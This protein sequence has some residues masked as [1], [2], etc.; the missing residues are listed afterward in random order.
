MKLLL[1]ALFSL[2]AAVA[3]AHDSLVPH[4]HP[5]G[6][7]ML[8]GFDTVAVALLALAAALVAYWKFGRT[9]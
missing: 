8:P 3:H 6:V 1:A 9:P 7:S 2:A 4:T 5:H